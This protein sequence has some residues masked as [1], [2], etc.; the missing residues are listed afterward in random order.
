MYGQTGWWYYFPVAFALK[1]TLPFLLVSIGSLGWG[2]WQLFAKKKIDFLWLLG[3]LFIYATLTMSSNI[4]IGI[5]HFLPVFPFLFI[6]GGALLDRLM[7]LRKS[8]TLT[9]VV[10]LLAP[11]WML[12]EDLHAYPDYIP[13]MNQLAWLHPHWDYLSDSNVECGDD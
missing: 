8:R 9:L 13:Y 10:V 4:N 11:G 3:P 12:W 7:S 6:L 1:T 2:T 5:R